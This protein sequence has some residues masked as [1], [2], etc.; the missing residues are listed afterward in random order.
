[1]LSSNASSLESL[2]PSSLRPTRSHSGRYQELEECIDRTRFHPKCSKRFHVFRS[3]IDLSCVHDPA[4]GSQRAFAYFSFNSNLLTPP[5]VSIMAP[6]SSP[7][8]TA[9]PEPSDIPNTICPSTP[10][11]SVPCFYERQ[12]SHPT[13]ISTHVLE[14]HSPTRSL[15]QPVPPAINE[16][17]II[18][19]LLRSNQTIP[20]DSNRE[21]ITK[22]EW[23]GEES[24][25][26]CFADFYVFEE[27]VKPLYHVR[28]E[29]EIFIFI[30]CGR[31][32]VSR[33]DPDIRFSRIK[34]LV[35]GADEERFNGHSESVE[36]LCGVMTG[37]KEC[38][39]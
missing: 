33:E 15:D 1:M 3:I 17:L 20:F 24:T 10:S 34:G 13:R 2:N 29:L 32:R 26:G 35:W 38:G 6:S 12:Y 36:V 30:V 7:L 14:I 18:S 22:G 9:P 31:F 25:L 4:N 8:A 39:V 23:N 11:L 21:P 5:S 37:P 19:L 16:V 28:N 27:T